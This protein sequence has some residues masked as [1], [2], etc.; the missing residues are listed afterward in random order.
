MPLANAK[1][2]SVTT[3]KLVFGNSATRYGAQSRPD[4]NVRTAGSRTPTAEQRSG[5]RTCEQMLREQ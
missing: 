2:S 1:R 5:L 3:A 4:L